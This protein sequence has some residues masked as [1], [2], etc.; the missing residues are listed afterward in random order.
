MTLECQH[1]IAVQGGVAKRGRESTGTFLP[2]HCPQPRTFLQ[3][4]L[5][6]PPEWG[7]LAGAVLACAVPL[8]FCSG[9][10]GLAVSSR[11]EV[12]R[13]LILVYG[14]G[15]VLLALLALSLSRPWQQVRPSARPLPRGLKEQ[16]FPGGAAMKE[17]RYCATDSPEPFGLSASRSSAPAPASG[18]DQSQFSRH[19]KRLVGVTPGQ[20][21]TPARI[22]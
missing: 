20:F 21:R 9:L 12:P 11:F 16:R 13:W 17:H 22:A 14:V 18:W 10:I 7:A 3:D 4:D 2:T 15:C 1:G 8:A 19:F 6:L 5:S